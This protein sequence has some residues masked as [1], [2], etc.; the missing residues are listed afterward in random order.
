MQENREPLGTWAR[1]QL[2]PLALGG[3]M[4]AASAFLA[5]QALMATM[6]VVVGA[7]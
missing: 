3:A 2:L 1:R 4:A 7:P 5:Y 6:R